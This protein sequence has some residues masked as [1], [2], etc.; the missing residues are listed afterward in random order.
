MIHSESVR[1]S[2]IKTHKLDIWWNALLTNAAQSDVRMKHLHATVQLLCNLV[3]EWFGGHINYL[4]KE[5]AALM[6]G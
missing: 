6:E 4:H 2:I 5:N 3:N 1:E